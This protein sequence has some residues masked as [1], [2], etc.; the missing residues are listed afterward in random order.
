MSACFDPGSFC[1]MPGFWG[2]PALAELHPRY[3]QPRRQGRQNHS[4]HFF[5][6]TFIDLPVTHRVERSGLLVEGLSRGIL[7]FYS[8]FFLFLENI[9][10]V[11]YNV[12]EKN[13]ESISHDYAG[14]DSTV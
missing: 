7:Q 1:R 13:K 12:F 14:C 4:S 6:H 3:H 2:L 8:L 10:G 5:S 9:E 11:L